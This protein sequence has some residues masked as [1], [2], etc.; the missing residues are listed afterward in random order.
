MLI[1]AIIVVIAADDVAVFVAALFS[2]DRCTAYHDQVKC[3][4]LL[5]SH[6]HT[7]IRKQKSTL[8]KLKCTKER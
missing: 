3:I 4:P 5:S 8:D 6:T 1:I 7:H 2:F